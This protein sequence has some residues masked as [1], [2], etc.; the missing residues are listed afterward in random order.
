MK[1]FNKNYFISPDQPVLHGHFPGRPILPG[2]M[3]LNF[4]KDTLSQEPGRRCRIKNIVRHKFIRPV[5]PEFSV[6]VECQ[7]KQTDVECR[8]FDQDGNLVASGQYTVEFLPL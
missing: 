3:L 4:V 2:V 7:L 5:L 1:I 8:I 6:R